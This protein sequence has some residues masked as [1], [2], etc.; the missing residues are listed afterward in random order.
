[1][2]TH[3]EKLSVMNH[4]IREVR[5]G[6]YKT[7]VRD[8]ECSCPVCKRYPKFA[9]NVTTGKYGCYGCGLHGKIATQI[10]ENR[11]KWSAVRSCMMDT[12]SPRSRPTGTR[13]LAVSL[14]LW[15]V[16][17]IPGDPPVSHPGPEPSPALVAQA[18]KYCLS[19][20]MTMAQVRKYRC[21]VIPFTPRVYFPYWNDT[22]SLSFY[23]GRALSPSI[24]PKTLEPGN[25]VVKPL[26]G[27]H[28][29]DR[30]NIRGQ[31]LPLVEGVFDHFAT[32]GSIASMG[33]YVSQEQV[34]GIRRLAP[35][36]V[37]VIYDPD[38]VSKATRVA[39]ML[40]KAG[41]RSAPVQWVGTNRDPGDLGYAVMTGVVDQ[42]NRM[43]IPGR[44]VVV[45]IRP[46]VIPS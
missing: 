9:I 5:L 33:S 40:W 31:M 35:S 46:T 6:N 30:G 29:L 28:V 26:F 12:N 3:D 32:P 15:P 22:D 43:S 42:L 8:L 17:G 11:D 18:L 44:L 10:A 38:A 25:G 13:S 14:P 34:D 27:L 20:G 19:R 45:R 24:E 21:S 16:S 37:P 7:R 23:M 39:N 2:I 41:I 36:W 4:V 1:M